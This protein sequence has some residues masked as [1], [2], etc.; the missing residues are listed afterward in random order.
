MS[1]LI[2][3]PSDSRMLRVL[4]VDD[5]AANRGVVRAILSAHGHESAEACSGVGALAA[6]AYQRFDVVLMD[7]N[8]PGLGGVEVTRLLRRSLG[9][10]RLT[11]VIAFTADTRY[12][13]GHYTALGFNGLL[14]KPA[15]ISAIM[16]ALHEHAGIGIEASGVRRAA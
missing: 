13:A 9:S 10:E 4:H 15:S 16:A 14:V 2:S 8:M 12:P 5:D 6:L 3:T 1:V 7:I 11:P